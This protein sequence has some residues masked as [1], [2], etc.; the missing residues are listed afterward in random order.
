MW[1]KKLWHLCLEW[2]RKEAEGSLRFTGNVWPWLEGE[3]MC[4]LFSLLLA[5]KCERVSGSRRATSGA[6]KPPTAW[7]KDI[8]PWL[9]EYLLCLSPLIH[10]SLW[11]TRDHFDPDWESKWF[12]PES[13][14]Y[15]LKDRIMPD[16][17]FSFLPVPGSR[18]RQM[19]CCERLLLLTGLC[20]P[21]L[22]YSSNFVVQTLCISGRDLSTFGTSVQI[23]SNMGPQGGTIGPHPVHRY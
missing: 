23:R 2:I 20:S 3:G 6:V 22:P 14:V 12:T 13:E 16:S 5:K 21:C 19:T 11:A 1:F 10:A 4:S 8:F 7:D 9:A 15:Y 18:A 17:W